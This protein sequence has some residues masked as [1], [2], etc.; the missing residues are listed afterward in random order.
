MRRHLIEPAEVIVFAGSREVGRTT[1]QADTARSLS[2]PVLPRSRGCRRVL[3]RSPSSRR[4][5]TRGRSASRWTGSRSRAGRRS[6]R[7][8]A[9]WLAL[10]GGDRVRRAAPCRRLARHG[11][12]PWRRVRRGRHCGHGVGRGGRRSGSSSEGGPAYVAVAALVVLAARWRWLRRALRIEDD[13]TAGLLVTATLVALAVRLVLL[14]H[15]QFYYPDVKVHALFAW[16]LAR[17][18]PRAVPRASSPP[19]SSATAS[20]CRWRTATGTRSP[21]RRVLRPDLAA[22]APGAL[23]ARGRGLARWPRS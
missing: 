7:R 10:I 22:G 4:P 3:S 5:P 19:T 9:L 23:S 8:H 18:G 1:I 15:P 2:H 17:H 6:S 21:I 11:A 13:R 20:A 14:L 12:V 16:Q